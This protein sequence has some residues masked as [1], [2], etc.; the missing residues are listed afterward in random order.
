VLAAYFTDAAYRPDG[1]RRLQAAG[2]GQFRE[3]MSTASGVLSRELAGLVRDGDPR[4]TSPS[5]EDIRALTMADI[6]GAIAPSIAKA[7]VEVTIVGNVAVED[8][9]NAT[10]KTFGALPP[11]AASFALPEKAR[12]VHFP[13][14]RATVELRHEG[15]EDQAAVAAAWPG[16]DL[17][18]DTRRERA[19]AILNEVIQLRL[20]DE[21]R[22]AQGG[23]YVPFGTYAASKSLPGFGYIVAGV[24][25]KPDAAPLFFTTLEKI[26]QELRDGV[27]SDDLLERARKPV[28]Y[29]H[30]AA[31]STN[32]YWV[33][34]LA[35]IQSDPRNLARVRSTLRDYGTITKEEVIAVARAFLDDARRVDIKVLPK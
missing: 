11:R 31:E 19:I 8:A 3:Q 22:E 27:L 33:A 34:A 1:L 15:R 21:V 32:A 12:A 25:P 24:E 20:I 9:I 35:D 13:L 4:W 29:Q 14:A 2:E 16:P 10:A 5:I 7:P 26:E 6:K 23:T 17:F 30:Y 18:S 28:L